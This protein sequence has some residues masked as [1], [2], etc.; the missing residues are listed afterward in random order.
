MGPEAF[1]ENVI[2]FTKIS[3]K[4]GFHIWKN[5]VFSIKSH[6]SCVPSLMSRIAV[7]PTVLG[8]KKYKPNAVFEEN[9]E[10]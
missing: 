10:N 2:H 8:R 7:D 5:K 6:M 3:F 9:Y 4:K 1:L